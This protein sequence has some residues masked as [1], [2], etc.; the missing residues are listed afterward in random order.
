VPENCVPEN[1]VPENEMLN[2]KLNEKNQ[3]NMKISVLSITIIWFIFLSV[4]PACTADFQGITFYAN[5]KFTLKT[6]DLTGNAVSAMSENIDYAG[7][8]NFEQSFD[9]SIKGRVSKNIYTEFFYDDQQ[10]EKIK[11]IFIQAE[12]G[13][14][15]S[16]AGDL[17]LD[18]KNQLF[19]LRQKDIRG[20]SISADKWGGQAQLFTAKVKGKSMR[21]TIRGNNTEG[22]FTLSKTG[23][24]L[25]SDIVEIDS[26]VL[27][28]NI[29]YTIDYYSGI[30]SFNP[31]LA[32]SC[33]ASVSY[34]Y[35]DE[36]SPA[37]RYVEGL[38]TKLPILG[39]HECT[40]S[41]MRKRDNVSSDETGQARVLGSSQFAAE[42]P[43][44]HR[45]IDIH[46]KL[47]L[48]PLVIQAEMA[49]S[50]YDSDS[51]IDNA[52]NEGS[53][54]DLKADYKTPMADIQLYRK[55]IG[56]SFIHLD[57][58]PGYQAGLIQGV[59][60][61]SRS[62]GFKVKNIPV[63]ASLTI[64]GGNG[65]GP[66]L[67]SGAGDFISYRGSAV[68]G[69]SRKGL[70]LSVRRIDQEDLSDRLAADTQDNPETLDNPGEDLI[71][72]AS[73]SAVPGPDEYIEGIKK[74]IISLEG[75]YEFSRKVRASLN[76]DGYKNTGISQAAGGTFQMTLNASPYNK[77]RI[78]SNIAGSTESSKS[79]GL[80]DTSGEVKIIHKL[81]G[82]I[83]LRGSGKITQARQLNDTYYSSDT[84]G[85][86]ENT[87]LTVH[88]SLGVSLKPLKNLSTNVQIIK[89]DTNK[90]EYG[91]K[92]TPMSMGSNISFK[93]MPFKN[94]N[95]LS[96]IDYRILDNGLDFTNGKEQGLSLNCTFSPTGNLK[97][98]GGI[99]LRDQLI[100]E[101][102]TKDQSADFSLNYKLSRQLK[103]K[104]GIS[105][106]KNMTNLN[107]YDRFSGDFSLDYKAGQN[108]TISLEY[109]Y[110]N[111]NDLNL[112][113]RD[114]DLK[115]GKMSLSMKI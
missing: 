34:D 39:K 79:A 103:I 15:V 50:Y 71:Q 12:K 112:S 113:Q 92:S 88:S 31:Y 11:R 8:S 33:T 26:R 84:A 28:R 97:I 76:M 85:V 115:T 100:K 63:S 110:K 49:R 32:S 70:K 64:E 43:L 81:P 111:Y 107:D 40:I 69:T 95:I 78:V 1:C 54:L 21:D 9:C 56:S 18:L 89:E 61:K 60:V 14:L 90:K 94:L 105:L 38:I 93:Y 36:F 73:K 102:R 22:P 7:D 109:N 17:S 106:G 98:S 99:S 45:V 29:E 55:Q 44:D 68:L 62:T 42:S 59:T 58:A 47:L 6:S 48:G 2:E 67:V 53:A 52:L 75:Q 114:Y 101:G 23:I 72:A 104:S 24:I 87:D 57:K 74:D 91:I 82:N 51:R 25:N 96:K 5:K 46:Q 66:D 10:E 13:S 77:T 27:T 86:N 108:M 80:Y 37:D 35:N 19:L 65:S 16:R 83:T 41:V 4:S 30:I 3:C 20:L